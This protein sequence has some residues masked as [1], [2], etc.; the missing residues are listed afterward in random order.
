MGKRQT[1]GSPYLLQSLYLQERPLIVSE[2]SISQTHEAATSVGPQQAAC[3]DAAL[4][5][6]DPDD[7][8]E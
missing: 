5:R 6:E 2:D 4:E 7:L 1:R 8:Y 3:L